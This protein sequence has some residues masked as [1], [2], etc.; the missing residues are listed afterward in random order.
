MA[1]RGVARARRAAAP[2]PA[3]TA[4]AVRNSTPQRAAT[5]VARS[6]GTASNSQPY[7]GSAGP[8]ENATPRTPMATNMRTRPRSLPPAATPSTA[9]ASAVRPGNST[10]LPGKNEALHSA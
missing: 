5:R 8:K 6:S 4:T 1:I 9:R 10:A 7:S 3:R 2:K